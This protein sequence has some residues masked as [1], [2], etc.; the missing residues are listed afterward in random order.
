[1]LSEI[2]G[3]CDKF[4]EYE[5]KKKEDEFNRLIANINGKLSELTEEMGKINE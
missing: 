2:K 1:M 3:D 5:N 4:K